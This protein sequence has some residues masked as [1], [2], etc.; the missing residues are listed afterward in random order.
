MFIIVKHE[1]LI[2]IY[3]H[4]LLFPSLHPNIPL[5][6]PSLPPIHPSLPFP[7][8]SH[9]SLMHTIPSPDTLP[10][11]SLHPHTLN[12]HT[13]PSLHPPPSIL[14][15]WSLSWHTPRSPHSPAAGH[16]PHQRR[17]GAHEWAH[18]HRRGTQQAPGTLEPCR[19]VHAPRT[20]PWGGRRKGRG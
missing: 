17:P 4:T 9:S 6:I 15:R 16:L 7:S 14:T 10:F 2:N 13:I 18:A 3:W 12:M 8:T 11:P 20:K 5:C 1:Y 19:T